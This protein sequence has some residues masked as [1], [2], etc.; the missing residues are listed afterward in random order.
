MPVVC[1]HTSQKPAGKLTSYCN[2]NK[3]CFFLRPQ[4]KGVQKIGGTGVKIGTTLRPL[5]KIKIAEVN[6]IDIPDAGLCCLLVSPTNVRL[7]S[8]AVTYFILARTTN[9]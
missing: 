3:R 6:E 5:K 2:Y 4:R 7:D 9:F 8:P 1:F